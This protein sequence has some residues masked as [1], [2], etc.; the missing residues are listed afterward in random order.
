MTKDNF[1]VVTGGP[2][3]GKSTVLDA[4]SR[5]GYKFVGETA[6]TIIKERLGK[7]LSPRPNPIEF[8]QQ[9]FD[10]DFKNYI[11]NINTSQLL[12]FDRSF[13]DSAAMIFEANKTETIGVTKI[14]ST[15]RFRKTV[16]IAPPWKEIYHNDS[17]RDQSYDDSVE[18]Y[19][20]LHKWYDLNDYALIQIPKCDIESRIHFILD[21]IK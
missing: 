9:I 12:F 21:N 19:E 17:E 14:L 18:I 10:I 1:V 13:L 20:K 8:A 5:L 6:R 2:G 15:Y 7:G 11:N 16:F 3:S 4:L